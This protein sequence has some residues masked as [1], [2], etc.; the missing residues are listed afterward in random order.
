MIPEMLT[1]LKYHASTANSMMSKTNM[2]RT[3]MNV[4][5]SSLV[6]A[7]S[8]VTPFHGEKESVGSLPQSHTTSKKKKTHRKAREEVP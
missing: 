6:S 1:E 4:N 2:L 3:S 5:P 8:L 7:V